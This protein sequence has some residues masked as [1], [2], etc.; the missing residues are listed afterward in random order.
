MLD[1]GAGTVD[2]ANEEMV[3]PMA[4]WIEISTAE[5]IESIDLTAEKRKSCLQKCRVDWES[6]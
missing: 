4:P 3:V 6:S 1:A 5:M 2:I